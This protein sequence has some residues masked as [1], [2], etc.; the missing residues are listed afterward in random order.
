MR[1]ASRPKIQ[2]EAWFNIVLCEEDR[3][4]NDETVICKGFQS[5][6]AASSRTASLAT[7]AKFVEGYVLAT[8]LF[9]V[10]C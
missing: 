9:H 7:V 5:V 4:T 10:S 3:I 8:N 6:A 2:Q 1:E